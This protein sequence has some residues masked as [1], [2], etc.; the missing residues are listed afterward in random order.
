MRRKIPREVKGSQVIETA[1]RWEQSTALRQ[2][3]HE[4][5]LLPAL[6]PMIL[7]AS[8]FPAL[9]C[10][11]SAREACCSAVKARVR[12]DFEVDTLDGDPPKGSS[13]CCGES[14]IGATIARDEAPPKDSIRR[15]TAP[16]PTTIAA[17]AAE[18]RSAPSWLRQPA[19]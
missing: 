8:E 4:E 13:S 11:R 16:P 10:T 14:S 7:A 18:V 1:D 5:K 12:T 15:T 9:R 2:I 17:A 3:L 19:A 6:T